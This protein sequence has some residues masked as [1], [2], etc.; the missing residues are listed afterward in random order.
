MD[1]LYV[2]GTGSKW[3]DNELKFSLRSIEKNCTGVDRVFIVGH[4]P[5]FVNSHVFHIQCSD[6]YDTKHKNI[7]HKVTFAI[8]HSDIAQHFLISS[9]DHFYIKPT[10]FNAY[11]IYNKQEIP[12]SV[13]KI[14]HYWQSLID[15]RKLLIENNL[16]IWQT[17]PHCNTHFDVSVYNENKA[18][19]DKG[20]TFQ[21]GAE[22]NCIMGNLLIS[23]GYPHEDYRDIKLNAD[24]TIYKWKDNVGDAHCISSAPNIYETY[25]GDFLKKEFPYKSKY[26]I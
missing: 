9:D 20:M 3:N 22:L 10:D 12:E 15:T 1:I 25:T 8:R 26:E 14:N 19:F 2:I 24:T 4:K 5:A 6:P 16:S 18:L 23:K 7:M 11:P 13:S 17:N 21:Y